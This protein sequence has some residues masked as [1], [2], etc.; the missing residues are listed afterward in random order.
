MGGKR[1]SDPGWGVVVD[2][3]DEYECASAA[4]AG[5]WVVA[6]DVGG[7]AAFADGFCSARFL[8]GTE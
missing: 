4:V 8:C 7:Y 2:W 6:G 3:G 1:G 5:E